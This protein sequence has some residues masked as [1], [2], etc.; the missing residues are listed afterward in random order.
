MEQL[1]LKEKMTDVETK[2]ELLSICE[3]IRKRIVAADSKILDASMIIGGY[4]QALE[5]P[6]EPVEQPEEEVSDVSEG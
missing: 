3:D 4:Y 1:E 6:P 5:S 2:T